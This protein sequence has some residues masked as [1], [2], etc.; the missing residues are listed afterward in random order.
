MDRYSCVT[1][2]AMKMGQTGSFIGKTLTLKRFSP[3]HAVREQDRSS[4]Q[5]RG[6]HVQHLTARPPRKTTRDGR[7]TPG[8]PIPGT[9]PAWRLSP[10][11]CPHGA[12]PRKRASRWCLC[13]PR[14]QC[15]PALP[16][17]V[18]KRLRR[19]SRSSLG[20]TAEEHCQRRRE[21]GQNRQR[22]GRGCVGDTG[23]GRA[24]N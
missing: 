19:L 9:T 17:R 14:Y 18:T 21:T 1:T 16:P 15:L 6:G 23:T 20:L 10:G 11:P 8:S 3:M 5:P 24:P 22:V 4:D 2:P 12:C 7:G 13:R